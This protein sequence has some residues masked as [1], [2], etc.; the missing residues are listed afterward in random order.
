MINKPAAATVNQSGNV[1]YFNWNVTSSQKVGSTSTFSFTK[2]AMTDEL[3]TIIVKPYRLWHA[4][5]CSV[6]VV[7]V[8]KT[9]LPIHSHQTTDFKECARNSWNIPLSSTYSVVFLTACALTPTFLVN[10]LTDPSSNK[11]P[12]ARLKRQHSKD[13]T[14][15]PTLPEPR[16]VP[17]SS[18]VPPQSLP[19]RARSVT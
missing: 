11:L 2:L 15:A 5:Y 14:L 12:I 1:L 3:Q 4:T 13:K 9:H 17:L 8:K 6:E 18:D 7:T 16:N 10:L 19:S